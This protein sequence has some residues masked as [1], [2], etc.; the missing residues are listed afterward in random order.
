MGTLTTTTIASRAA[1]LLQDDAYTHWSQAELI[2]WVSDAVR[3]LAALYPPACARTDAVSLVEGTRQSMPAG[4][5]VA[6]D[7]THNMGTD[8]STPGAAVRR[9]PRGQLDALEPNWHSATPS[10]T[11][12]VVMYQ[13]NNPRVFFVSPPQPA[14]AQ[15]SL[16][17]TYAYAPGELAV[18]EVLPVGDE[19]AGTLVNLVL[20][21]AYAKDSER[22][23]ASM[24]E[25]FQNTAAAQITAHAASGGGA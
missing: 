15:G 11:V 16:E 22:A 1:L 3:E 21:R 13:E 4:A 18:D 9:V 10:A 7:F 8:Q 12:Q 14:S 19:W 23:S 5:V 20:A 25:F 6:I 24:A 2:G 17:V